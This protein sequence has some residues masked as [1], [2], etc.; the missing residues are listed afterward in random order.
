MRTVSNIGSDRVLDA[1]RDSTIEGRSLDLVTERL[2]LFAFDEVRPDLN[3]LSSA[4][5]MVPSDLEALELL[6]GTSDRSARNRLSSRW[7]ALKLVEWIEQRAEIRWAPDG[8]PQGIV[9]V[10]DESGA[11]SSA[12]AGSFALDTPGIGMAPGNPLSMVQATE[13]STESERF[14]VWFEETWAKL[15]DHSGVPGADPFASGGRSAR[16]SPGAWRPVRCSCL[17]P[18]AGRL[19]GAS[20]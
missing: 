14:A 18:A 9:V 19:R 7:L 11:A 3:R 4:R 1:L 20:W 6:G 12:L 13:S 2:S 5:Q 8:I 16:R 10:K 17:R 15:E